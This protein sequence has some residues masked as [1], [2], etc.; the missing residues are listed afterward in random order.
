VSAL[1][2]RDRALCATSESPDDWFPDHGRQPE[3]VRLRVERTCAACPVRAEC[4]AYAVE[5]GERYGI[6]GGMTEEER[7]GVSL[8][9]RAASRYCAS[10]RHLRTPEGTGARGTCLACRRESDAD[11][12]AAERVARTGSLSPQSG[13]TDDLRDRDRGGRFALAADRAQATQAA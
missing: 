6:W 4:L 10:G 13:R 3:R 11:R 9:R 7:R 5:N 12:R 8:P 2:W 1:A